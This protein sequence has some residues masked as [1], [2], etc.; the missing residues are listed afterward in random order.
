MP[1]TFKTK[2]S[3]G[4]GGPPL[5]PSNAKGKVELAGSH[6]K[7][8][9][10]GASSSSAWSK[11]PTLN[12]KATHISAAEVQVP[13]AA[14]GARE[15]ENTGNAAPQNTQ[16]D[17]ISRLM[18]P[19]PIVISETNP[20][21]IQDP[22]LISE[23]GKHNPQ[24]SM[25]EVNQ[26]GRYEEDDVQSPRLAAAPFSA[27]GERGNEGEDKNLS[28]QPAAPLSLTPLLRLFQQI[29]F[30]SSVRRESQRNSINAFNT[31][32]GFAGARN[33]ESQLSFPSS[34]SKSLFT[35]A[36]IGKCSISDDPPGTAGQILTEPQSPRRLRTGNQSG[37]AAAIDMSV[38]E[39]IKRGYRWQTIISLGL[40]QL[41]FQ[42]IVRVRRLRAVLEKKL[43]PVL[44][45]RK[46]QTGS[47]MSREACKKLQASRRVPQ[48]LNPLVPTYKFLTDSYPLFADFNSPSLMNL[49]AE[50]A[51]V[52]TYSRGAVV[53]H[54]GEPAQEVLHFIVTGKVEYAQQEETQPQTL[55][56]SFFEK[57]EEEREGDG[58]EGGV[59]KTQKGAANPFL[60]EGPG[61]AQ[62]SPMYNLSGGKRPK[63]PV[64]DGSTSVPGTSLSSSRG[65]PVRAGKA[66][67][68]ANGCGPGNAGGGGAGGTAS[69]T[70]GGGGGAAPKGKK[71]KDDA[72]AVANPDSLP[73]STLPFCLPD[74]LV[75]VLPPSKAA[76]LYFGGVQG[77][78][79][80]LRGGDHFG[81]LFGTSAIFEGSYR[82][83][84]SRCVIWS[85]SRS[86]FE[87][88]FFPYADENMKAMYVQYFRAHGE[89][90]ITR[91][92]PLPTTLL[93]VSIYRKLKRSLNRYK[94]DFSPCVFLRGE[95]LFDQDEA[96]KN[97]YCMLEG[98]MLRRCKGVDGTFSTGVSQ[99]LGL[100]SFLR[101]CRFIL[102]G[103]EGLI[104][105]ATHRF[106]C[107]VSSP[108]AFCYRVTADRFI[109][110]LLDDPG[111]YV[112]LRERLMHQIRMSMRLD[113]V[114]LKFAPLLKDFPDASLASIAQGAE[115][116]VLRRS[117]PLCE[118][119]HTIK[120]I[121]LVVRGGIRDTRVFDRRPTRRLDTPPATEEENGDHLGD[122]HTNGGGY[123]PRGRRISFLNSTNLNGTNS[124]SGSTRRGIGQGNKTAGFGGTVQSGEGGNSSAGSGHSKSL[125]SES[126]VGNGSGSKGRGVSPS[127]AVATAGGGPPQSGSAIRRC[128]GIN[129][130]GGGAGGGVTANS[131][132]R[133]SGNNAGGGNY[134]SNLGGAELG[135]GTGGGLECL[136]IF[137]GTRLA[138]DL[139]VRFPLVTPDEQAELNPPLPLLPSKRFDVTVGGGWEGLLVD[140][141]PSGWEGTCT[142]EAWAL[143]VLKIRTEFNN[144]PKPH[145]SCIL[146]YLRLQQKEA[147]GLPKIIVTKLPPMSSYTMLMDRP[148][149]GMGLGGTITGESGGG[150]AL[151]V[152]NGSGGGG[153]SSAM[154]ST[155]HLDSSAS[156]KKK[157]V[158]GSHLPSLSR[159]NERSWSWINARGARGSSG[160]EGGAMT[161]GSFPNGFADLVDHHVTKTSGR[162]R[163]RSADHLHGGEGRSGNGGGGGISSHGAPRSHERSTRRS[164][165]IDLG[166]L[167][168]K[169][170]RRRRSS[171]HYERERQGGEEGSHERNISAGAASSSPSPS[172]ER[173]KG[174][175][176]RGRGGK[177]NRR[178][179]EE[180]RAD[181]ALPGVKSKPAIHTYM[182]TGARKP[183]TRNQSAGAG[184]SQGNSSLSLPLAV[185]PYLLAVY[186]GDF[187]DGEL[188]LNNIERD[189]VATEGNDALLR[190]CP[191]LGR[192]N[193]RGSRWPI[194]RNPDQRWF[195]V[196]PSYGPLPGTVHNPNIL[197]PA[198]EFVRN[199]DLMIRKDKHYRDK[200]LAETDFFNVSMR[201]KQ[202]IT[203]RLN[204]LIES[205]R[206]GGESGKGIS[207]DVHSRVGGSPSSTIDPRNGKPLSPSGTSAVPKRVAL[208]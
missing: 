121:F 18:K 56:S 2:L 164:A 69:T 93:R 182:F 27:A 181:D 71:R 98:T 152:P 177:G 16:K 149:G 25:V 109:S 160:D 88:V 40:A 147:L 191:D 136:D 47:I 155:V 166:S 45:A 77:G 92:Y 162:P 81:G 60:R 43:L 106:Q 114:C 197:V 159:S 169:G 165:S 72:N 146:N 124:G 192:G 104:L 188:A 97:V 14:A 144:F 41:S 171:T 101:A 174:R 110:A 173:L 137:S 80:V 190:H 134:N 96:P 65:A 179:S 86:I 74:A 202:D 131:G 44:E 201:S 157:K 133:R 32:S 187:K 54:S 67:F 78:K 135:E 6:S 115:A 120:E 103:A 178:S 55:S 30:D 29:G 15:E 17:S 199:S 198:P 196:V 105:T 126:K 58:L 85:I 122:E 5:A 11:K 22:P 34:S 168:K 153:G 142:V 189:P 117:V 118:P 75:N 176:R 66:G 63:S 125:H 132:R 145:Q 21:N 186:N 172:C 143:P 95:K 8:K 68:S 73:T 175:G 127:A 167:K 119:A 139:L 206:G 111:L 140:K 42:N 91:S 94:T 148:G 12:K 107:T 57:K 100:N 195:A 208:I 61:T 9:N 102:L 7:G 194:I 83:F 184:T 70:A 38:F 46:E 112:H 48:D 200:L 35:G 64:P 37:D 62:S 154:S 59:G 129:G 138:E 52:T 84:S 205:G 163:H 13:H 128:Q 151:S 28:S 141:W 26:F 24:F 207:S 108:Y 156:K 99:L 82:V 116:R 4:G 87:S 113:P 90:H 53:A 180:G 51:D 185:D 36:R 150:G 123:F 19:P 89:E 49:I 183:T 203:I 161:D 20:F 79:V 3:G 31:A 170:E 39:S 130:A 76:A 1:D 33:S 193:P 50:K 204:E 10:I 158:Q 23:D